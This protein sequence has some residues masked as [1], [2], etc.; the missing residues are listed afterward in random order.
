MAQQALLLIDVDGV[1]NPFSARR[2]GYRS[3]RYTPDGGWYRNRDPR[4]RDG[5]RVRLHHGHGSRLQALADSANL[6]L[7]WATT[8][9]HDANRF[10]GPAIGLPDIAVI[11][12]PEADL[13]PG[14]Y[15]WSAWTDTGGWKWPAVAAYA[16]GRPLA[17]LDD[18]FDTS[19]YPDA[20][21]EF[22]RVRESTP[23]LLC[24]V[25]PKKGLLEHNLRDVAGWAAKL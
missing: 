6:E 2:L 8:W 9:Q 12:F 16:D 3:Y 21:A 15:G 23:T 18:D 7:A 10:V 13:A 5:L 17:W 25:D 14:P 20:R 19:G 1:L 4:G 11:E 24:H 22:D